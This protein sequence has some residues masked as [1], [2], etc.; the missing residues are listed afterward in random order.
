MHEKLES[1]NKWFE[2]FG[3][4]G[5]GKDD[6]YYREWKSASANLNESECYI[7]NYKSFLINEGYQEND[8]HKDYELMISE[9]HDFRLE[10]DQFSENQESSSL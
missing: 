7:E 8:I 2:Q 10:E 3:F 9:N 1:F 4:D 6:L 5:S